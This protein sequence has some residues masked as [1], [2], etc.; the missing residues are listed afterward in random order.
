MP[1]A[2]ELAW[3]IPVLPQGTALVKV[4][5]TGKERVNRIGARVQGRAGDEK[6]E[7]RSPLHPKA[8][9]LTPFARS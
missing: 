8:Q 5:H 4:I 2:A 9:S 1:S 6:R 3:L 7:A